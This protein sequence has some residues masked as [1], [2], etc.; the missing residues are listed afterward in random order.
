LRFLVDANLSPRLA[1][2]LRAAG[3]DAIHVCDE[4][5]LT[6]DDQTILARA[7]STSRAVI[8]ADA[9]FA[10]LL[11]VAGLREPSLVLLRSADRLTLDQQAN[12]LLANLDA[13]AADV[14]SGAVV[15]FAFACCLWAE[16][17]KSQ[18]VRNRGRE[19]GSTRG[20]GRGRRRWA[21]T[22]GDAKGPAPTLCMIRPAG[23]PRFSTRRPP[24]LRAV[25]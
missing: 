14:E 4:S 16:A 9:D 2:R 1:A 12:L 5:L 24:H 7:A 18:S 15:T 8:S 17:V 19:L 20:C 23:S 21:W 3:H 6:A 10:A 22:T 13:V 11:A 25:S